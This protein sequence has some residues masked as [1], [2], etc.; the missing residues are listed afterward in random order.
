MKK[1][2]LFLDG[3]W[4]NKSNNTNISKMYKLC[5][6]ESIVKYYD[7]GV[8][9]SKS[10]WDKIT[11]GVFGSGVQKNIIEA[12]DFIKRTYEDGDQIFIYGFSR[13]AFTARSLAGFLDLVG[14][15]E[16]NSNISSLTLFNY[17]K[18]KKY[19]A[20]SDLI[21][22]DKTK[23]VNIKMIGVFDTVKSIGSPINIGGINKN[24]SFHNS[25]L[26]ENTE[27]A[28]HAVS[29]D[30]RRYNF[31]PVLWTAK[32]DTQMVKQRY[33]AG[34]HSD[35]GGGYKNNDTASLSALNWMIKNSNICGLNINRNK[36]VQNVLIPIIH[37]G[38]TNMF[39]GLYRKLSKPYN[40]KINI[41][42][43]GVEIDYSV[44]HRLKH[45]TKYKPSNLLTYL[46]YFS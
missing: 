3:S 7:G 41:S 25:H 40:R 26:C 4:Q 35:V 42:I 29:I 22:Q 44:I 23:D 14:L 31:K 21:V 15:P 6:D 39:F 1:I 9:S 19:D 28:F 46:K 45:D 27:N 37:D 11:G 20:I 33:F 10:I 34:D 36:E 30:E 12:Y 16:K 32:N 43:L 24:W 13:G 17:Y 8:G 38:Y 5:T 18:E 2:A